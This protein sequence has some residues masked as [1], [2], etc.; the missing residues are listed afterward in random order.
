MRK[1]FLSEGNKKKKGKRGTK[2]KGAG[3]GEKGAGRGEV[4]EEV[5]EVKIEEEGEMEKARDWGKGLPDEVK[6]LYWSGW[7]HRKCSSS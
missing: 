4:A 7:S 3:R 5:E 6:K 1:G 2:G